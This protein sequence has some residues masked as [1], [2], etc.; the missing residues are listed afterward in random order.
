MEQTP[1]PQLLP[2][3][4]FLCDKVLRSKRYDDVYFSNE[5][6]LAET[7]HVFIDGTGLRERLAE[8]EHLIIAETGFGTG[9]NFLAVV[10]EVLFLNSKTK[11]DF[12]SVEGSPISKDK[13]AAA[14][15]PFPELRHICEQMLEQWPR[16]WLGV[17]H[18]S[19]LHGQINLH[20]HYGQAEHVLPT[21]NFAADIW[22][23]DGF[24]PAKNPE[25]WSEK[26]LSKLHVYPP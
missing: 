24:S 16:R 10:A 23:L 6:G 1:I 22:F 26:L 4:A 12:V 2:D 7:R 19:F 20:L 13:V 21:L 8:R 9:L 17:H 15:R 25:I 3:D 14:L 18:M 11:I 5:N